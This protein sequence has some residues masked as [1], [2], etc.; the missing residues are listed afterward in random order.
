MDKMTVRR[1]AEICGGVLA[2][3]CPEDTALRQIVIDSREVKPGDLFAAFRG[4][5]TDGHRFIGAAFER[6]AACCL[7]EKLP[8]GE[9]RP[10]ILV[11][12]VLDAMEKLAAAYRAQFDIPVVGITGSV[13]KTTAKEM[14]SAVLEQRYRTLKTEGNLNNRYGIPMMLSRLD[15]SCQAAVIEMGISEFGE[16]H[17]LAHMV[18]PTVAVY[19]VIGHAHLEFLQDLD[20]VLRAKT[21]MLD[22]I[23]ETA[24]VLVNGDDERLAAFPCRQ[25]KICFGLGRDCD[26]RAENIETAAELHCDIVCGLRRIPV[27]IPAFGIQHVHAALAAA[28]VG[29]LLGLSDEEIAAGIA[30]FRNVGRRGELV[31]TDWLTLIDDSYN[32]NPDSVRCGIDSLMQIPAQRHL[33]MLGDMLE[34]GEESG[35]LHHETGL[36]AAQKGVDLV[37]TSGTFAREMS[38]G[39]GERGKHFESREALI[40]ALPT[41][42]RRGDAVLVK[43]SK[44]SHFETVAAALRGWKE[45]NP[46]C[47]LLD[48]DDTILDFKKAEARAL[49]RSLEELGAPVT[50]EMLQRYNSI[51]QQYWER[52]ERGKITRA[53][54]LLGRFVQFLQEFGLDADPE[55]LRDRYMKNLSQGHFFVEGA[56][57]LLKA[58]SGKYRLFLVSNGTACVQKGRLESAGIVPYF[59]KIFISEEIGV[60]KPDPRFFEACFEKMEPFDRSRCMIVGDSLTSDILG[61]RNAGITTC[62]FNLRGREARGDVVP[63]WQISRLDELPGL[64]ESLYGTGGE[65]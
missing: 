40:A 10:V 45:E 13:G 30:D 16:M 14:I 5:K 62:W 44:G 37:V 39:A 17:H 8:S 20:G 59:E 56:E 36:Y 6:G 22:D 54:V 28:A 58:L 1:A 38:R 2:G 24:P 53:Q 33:C 12:D 7:A 23:P 60:N 4:E 32:A 52:L 61:G 19:T 55:A 35:E 9:T 29:M 27:R 11:P 47:I 57:E 50:D 46:A 48:M 64:L 31:R 65:A 63:D 18:Q 41:L 15:E 43:A 3:A 49:A 42:V 26:V 21:E 34:L 51:N 25:R